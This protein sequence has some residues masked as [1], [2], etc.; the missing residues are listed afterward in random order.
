MII[1]N[2]LHVDDTAGGRQVVERQRAELLLEMQ[3]AYDI[4]TELQV[5][6]T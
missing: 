3:R 1:Y 6:L 4:A 5:E 2:L